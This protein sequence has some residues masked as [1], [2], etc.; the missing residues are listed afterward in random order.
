M[1]L[2]HTPCMTLRNCDHTVF[3]RHLTLT[4]NLTLTQR[5]PRPKPR[6]LGPHQSHRRC[7]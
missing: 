5:E 1:T 2:A 4:V 3:A 6:P 7:I